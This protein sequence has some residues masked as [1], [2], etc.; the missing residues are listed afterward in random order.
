M[1]RKQEISRSIPL[2]ER[3]SPGRYAAKVKFNAE[4]ET[5]VAF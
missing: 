5:A 4:V 1:M 3:L 2:M